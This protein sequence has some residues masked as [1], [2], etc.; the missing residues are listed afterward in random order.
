MRSVQHPWSQHAHMRARVRPHTAAA[1]CPLL[2][3]EGEEGEEAPKKG[4][5][6][7]KENAATKRIREEMERRRKAEEEARRWERACTRVCMCVLV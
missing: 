4:G 5:K 6:P 1:H 7:V 2:Q 3:A